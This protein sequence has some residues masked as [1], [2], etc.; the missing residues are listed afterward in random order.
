[1]HNVFEEAIKAE[2]LAAGDPGSDIE[3]LLT[4]DE[5]AGTALLRD[6]R[7]AA[8]NGIANDK[9]TQEDKTQPKE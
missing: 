2:E 5:D 3:E 8:V 7:T 6:L 4:T 1:V 9:A